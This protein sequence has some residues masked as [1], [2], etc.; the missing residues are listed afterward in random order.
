[1]Y[2]LDEEK[3]HITRLS[4]AKAF[5]APTIARRE[6]SNVTIPLPSP[7]LPPNLYSAYLIPTRPLR[8]E[9]IWSLE[10]GYTG[11]LAKGFTFTADGYIQ[12]CDDLIGVRTTPD[13]LGL[14]RTFAFTDNVD[15]ALAWGGTTEL[16]Y[17]NKI[18]KLSAWYSYNVFQ[19]DQGL[20]EQDCLAYQPARHKA[21]L[22]GRLFLPGDW[23]LN[24][25]FRYTVGSNIRIAS[26]NA[27]WR[28]SELYRLDVT[29]SKKIFKDHGEIMI[30][31]ADLLNKNDPAVYG[32]SSGFTAAHDTPGRTFFVRFQLTF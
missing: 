5:R 13:P 4:I 17:E 27:H 21:G 16:A 29:V 22:T 14:G 24:G 32:Y 2:A 31:V 23:T 1:M 8:N 19:V 20:S 26:S 15:G 18:G 11:H 7:P 6:H 9:E 28:S 3:R 30:G 10:A 12:R 25:N